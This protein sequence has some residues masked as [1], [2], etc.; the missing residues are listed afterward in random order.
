MPISRGHVR[1][2]DSI[3]GAAQF[4]TGLGYTTTVR[5]LDVDEVGLTGV[6]EA[7][8]LKS[9]RRMRDGFAVV[10]AD[11][12]TKPRSVRPLA[13]MLQRRIHDRPLGVLGIR[14]GSDGSWERMIVF[15]PRRSGRTRSGGGVTLAR[16]EIDLESPTAHDISVLNEIRWRSGDEDAAHDAIDRALDVERVTDRFFVGLRS[17][18][19]QLRDA[20]AELMDRDLA[21]RDQLKQL[22]D[23]PAERA[24]LR[25]L[26]QILF[27][28]FVQRKGLIDEEVNWLRKAWRRKDGP[29]YATVLEPLFYECLGTPVGDRRPHLPDAPYLNGG[30]FERFYGEVSLDLPDPVFDLEDGLLGFLGGW[31]FTIAEEMP[32]ESEVA[33][34]PEML[35]K[36]FEHL[37][38][39]D[40]VKTDG[41]VYTPRPVVHFMC[42]EALVPWLED[43]VKLPEEP[44]RVLLT[45]PDPFDEAG[46]P[47]LLGPD[48][49]LRIARE[50]PGVLD[51]LKILDPAVGSGAFPMGMLAE[52]VRLR[53]LCHEALHGREP[54]ASTVFGWKV[55]AIRHNLYGVDIEPRAI[56]LCRLRFWLALVVDLPEGV[57]AE[58]LP[59]LEY[60]TVVADS[61]V[62]FSH[63][64]EVQN[65]RGGLSYFGEPDLAALH[66]RWFAA[67]G[68]QRDELNHEIRQRENEVVTRQLD[69][70]R[71]S[72]DSDEQRAQIDELGE[73]FSSPDRV[74]PCFVPAVHAPE[75][76]ENSGWDIV[77][78]NPPYVERKAVPRRLPK[79]R[80]DDLKRHYGG[81][82]DLMILFAQRA[83]Q[84]SRPGGI[85][86]MIF[87]D[88]IFTS[89]DAENL[90]REWFNQHSVLVC[91]RTKCFEGK[92]VNGGVVV[93]RVNTS[94]DEQP[95][96]WVEG[97]RRPVVDFAEASD[98]LS[99]AAEPGR[100][101]PAGELEVFSAPGGEYQRLPHRPL[102]RPSF[103]A[104]AS[105]DRFEACRNW[106]DLWS[107]WDARS[108]RGWTALSN[109]RRLGTTIADLQKAGFY[110]SLDPGD[111]V[112]L[113]LVVEGG[114][115]LAT[116]DDKRFLAAVDGT[117]EA[118][119]HRERQ[120]R[121]EELTLQ[122]DDAA[123]LYRRIAADSDREAALLAV[124]EQ[125][126]DALGWPRVGTFR[127][128]APDVVR[129]QP[130]SE[131]EREK[132]IVG[133]PTFVPFEKG[134]D[135]DEIDG[136]AIGAAWWRDNPVVIDWSRDAVRVLRER[137]R[138]GGRRSPRIQNEALWFSDGVTW[139]RVASY[140][141]ARQVPNTA[142]F[143]SESP[144]ILPRVDWLDAG[145]LLALLNCEVLDFMLRT[146]LGSRMHVEI[147]D[148]RRVP[149]PVLG[150]EQDAQLASLAQEASTTK[151]TGQGRA[152]EEIEADV[153]EFVRDLYRI[154]SDADFWVVR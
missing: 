113:G 67:S 139:N 47:A 22:G 121:F 3:E 41:T 10:I 74:F 40:R 60:R 98:K 123:D 86:S 141:R 16:L 131:E 6:N 26:T 45:E 107:Q 122:H 72:A 134:D 95:L 42:R 49:S 106:A 27:V 108:R 91:A 14:G 58:P 117:T 7:A 129:T 133:G 63:G 71:S 39:E 20:I 147:G 88:S 77:I 150:E 84:Y 13:K 36:V 21:A 148:I 29:Y 135:S 112:L 90:R 130:L 30:L 145:A 32:D 35:G 80:V 56:E 152:V 100:W 93:T 59:N 15:R 55:D 154:P 61:L 85:V 75:V 64:V 109:T 5:P 78:M 31:T 2:I 151:R 137:A 9:G 104:L 132:G 140:L 92:A 69:Q 17:H 126:D 103:E 24:A 89:A 25:I 50:L 81:T 57:D 125:F 153:N 65:T 87:N 83:L 37:A 66:D 136:H 144:T 1:A 96:R 43:A 19:D 8:Y 28:E 143:S 33:V 34:D 46:L 138:A 94:G 102:F 76:A 127:I 73:R 146:L 149:I 18:F 105:L 82:A 68:G 118:D 115:G 38:G 110:D 99:F 23:E 116:A 119:V 48:E 97:Y 62:D 79:W 70:A 51:R 4:F 120:Q 111:W 128:A 142:I 44:A 53:S 124:W 52:I 114:Q 54:D 11:T 101:Q 12:E